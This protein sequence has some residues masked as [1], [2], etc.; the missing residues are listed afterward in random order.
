MKDLHKTYL[1]DIS[2]NG[3]NFHGFQSQT[4]GMAIQ[5]KLESALTTYLREP[6]K[7]RGASRTDSGVHALAQKAV[8][9]TCKAIDTAKFLLGINALVPNGIGVKKISVVPQGFNPMYEAK[10]KI[11]RYTLWRG[12]CFDPFL[13]PFI[14]QVPRQLDFTTLEA[15]LQKLCGKH[16][17]SSF[18]SI[19]SSAKTKVRRVLET[20]VVIYDDCCDL[21]FLG[22]GFLKQMIRIMVGTVVEF[23]LGKLSSSSIEEILAC[24]DREK[25]GITAPGQGLFLMEVFLK[26]QAR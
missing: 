7:L 3:L 15:H 24:K 5:D 8:F 12:R 25:A 17:F 6:I 26:N 21:W 18:C 23:S 13:A 11:Y 4:D 16:D 9:S 22:E 14:W 10:A 19:D 1:L 2:Y 20:K